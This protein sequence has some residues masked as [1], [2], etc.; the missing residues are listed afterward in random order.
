ML[1][2][3]ILYG[4]IMEVSRKEEEGKKEE[5]ERKAALLPM[6]PTWTSLRRVLHEAEKLC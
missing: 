3:I 6:A 1:R 2:I 4:H 5:K